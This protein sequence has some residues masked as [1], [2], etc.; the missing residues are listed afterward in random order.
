METIPQTENPLVLRTDFSDDVVW[1]SVCTAIRR[2]V[3]VYR[4]LAYVEFLDDVQYEGIGVT[5]LLALI[6]KDYNHT[7]II[8]ADGVTISHPDH[9]L[10]IVDLYDQPGRSFRA[11]PAA[12]QAIENNLSLANMDFEDFSE[13]VDGDGIFRDPW[14]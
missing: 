13:S 5:R 9:P 1:Q 11:I 10:L 3:G 4:F 14:G 12:I 6:P 8:V 7:F 2:P